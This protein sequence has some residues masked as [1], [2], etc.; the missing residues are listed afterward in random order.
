MSASGKATGS[1]PALRPQT[2]D[3]RPVAD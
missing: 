2:L 1:D 3:I